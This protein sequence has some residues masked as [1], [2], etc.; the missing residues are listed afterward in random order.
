MRESVDFGSVHRHGRVFQDLREYRAEFS[1]VP[2]S[3]LSGMKLRV[4]L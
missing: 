1:K 3:A 2:E 4:G